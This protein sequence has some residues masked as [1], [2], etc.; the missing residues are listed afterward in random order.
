[1]KFSVGN[2]H[3]SNLHSVQREWCLQAVEDPANESISSD[4]RSNLLAFFIDKLT[5][6]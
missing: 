5:D 2:P 3:R 1:M 6:Q 4:E